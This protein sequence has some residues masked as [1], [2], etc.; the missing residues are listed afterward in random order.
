MADNA[1]ILAGGMGKRMKSTKPKVLL[2]VL[3]EPM[4]EWVIRACEDSGIADICIVKG[5][6]HGQVDEYLG[7][8]YET[9]LQ[10]QRLGTG[11]AVM[12]AI[13]FLEK[14]RSS[15]TLILC[16]DAPFIDRETIVNAALL[17]KTEKNAVTVVSAIADDP[18][19]YGRV[20]R[21]QNGIAGIAEH[22]DCNEEQL[23][24]REINSGCYWFD[25][26]A[27]LSVLGEIRPANAQGEYY[28]TD[29]VELLLK[30]G[31]PAG[32]Y[33]SE[34]PNVS[35]GA[36]DRRGLLRLNEIAR[37]EI[38]NRHL[39]NG[40]E[41]SCLDG[42]II[43]RDV[44]IGAGTHI[45]SG[46]QLFG[47]TRVGSGCVIGC[48][49]VLRDTTVGNGAVLNN[50]YAVD[51]VIED[52]ASIGPWV[53]LRPGSHIGRYAKIGDFVE[54]KNSQIGDRTAVAHLTYVGDSDVGSNVNFG[55]GCVTV[56]YDGESKHRTVIGN[57]AFIGCNTNLV[58]PVSIGVGAY[59]AAGSTITGD[60]PD[61]A[62]AI[63][64]GRT[65][66][67]EGY[68]EK[69]LAKRNEK[70]AELEER[71]EQL[72]KQSEAQ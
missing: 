67:K 53:Q 26:D 24:I 31:L 27:L 51:S 47:R 2:E 71:Q 3:G 44:E 68:A 46:S 54:I 35:L 55:C 14:N 8:R 19:G 62:L 33:V 52:G 61:G 1:V 69:K 5:Y 48:G 9:V 65:V 70:F 4:L 18:S 21:N 63:E 36:N 23:R 38:I 45:K 34:N 13:P 72:R 57:N 64:R 66:L 56:N 39:D 25:T 59:T 17:H 60:V 49:T 10:A 32:A 42:V 58:A 20:L 28:L 41:F 29:C 22:K 40:V 7:G 12:Q 6:G 16:G 43:G 37:T 11:H 15:N 30:K 50:V